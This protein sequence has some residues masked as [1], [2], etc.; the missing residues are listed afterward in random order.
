MNFGLWDR[1]HAAEAVDGDVT[2]VDRLLLRFTLG[3]EVGAVDVAVAILETAGVGVIGAGRDKPWGPR[4]AG[5]ICPS[6]MVCEVS[7]TL[8][9]RHV[10]TDVEAVAE[11]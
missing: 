10:V 4:M 6:G 9:R 2:P 11:D 1:V 7:E 5:F 8:D 3:V